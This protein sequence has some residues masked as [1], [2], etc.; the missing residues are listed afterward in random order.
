MAMYHVTLPSGWLDFSLY[1]QM[2]GVM[3]TQPQWFNQSTVFTEN[4][5]TTFVL[6]NSARAKGNV[7]SCL[8]YYS[9]L[10]IS[11]LNFTVCPF[12]T[13]Q[14]TKTPVS[15]SQL[16]AQEPFALPQVFTE[17]QLLHRSVIVSKNSAYKLSC[18]LPSVC[19]PSLIYSLEWVILNSVS[20]FYAQLC[21]LCIRLRY[22]L[23]GT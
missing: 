17:F 22:L 12:Q 7:P 19:K 20:C 8:G 4:P 11:P 14:N 5:T 15:R 9:I 16:L 2:F 3:Q 10:S 13:N 21:I 1:I 6:D 18:Y 23:L